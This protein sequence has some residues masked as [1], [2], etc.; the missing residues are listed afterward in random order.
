[1]IRSPQCAAHKHIVPFFSQRLAAGAVIL[2]VVCFAD[3]VMA[4]ADNAPRVDVE[5]VATAPITEQVQLTGT[6]TSPRVAQVSPSVEGLVQM[7][8]VDAGDRVDPGASLVDLDSEL[9]EL[10]LERTQ[11]ATREAREQLADAQRRF[12]EAKRLEGNQSISQTELLSREAEVQVA[13]AAVARLEAAQR[14]QA[15]RVARHSL[16][17]PFPGVV[18]R[19]LTEAG[20]WVAPGTP[21][22]ELVAL[23]GLRL[24]FRAPQTYFPRVDTQTPVSV[25]LDALPERRLDGRITA[26]IPV[27]DPEARTFMVRVHLD[28]DHVA[29]TPGMSAHALLD[30]ETGRHS[31][32]VSRDALIRY[33]DGRVT[34][35]VIE[36]TDGETTVSERQ[37]QTGLAFDGRVEIRS[38]LDAGE[39]VVVR[40]NEALQEGQRVRLRGAAG[41]TAS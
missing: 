28:D 14:H 9:A 4:Q 37:V 19:K 35:W 16:A 30:L 1:M 23:D 10:E 21:V 24:D 38:G 33:P 25:R 13:T 36:E 11:A 12:D 39:R 8:H 7:V 18:S 22:A 17:A 20:E 34:V 15:E 29:M 40:G 5:V 2:T 32:T 3:R 31:T 41:A 27:S 26:I 6:V